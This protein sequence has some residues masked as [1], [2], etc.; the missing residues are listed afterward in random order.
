MPIKHANIAAAIQ[1]EALSILHSNSHGSYIISIFYVALLSFCF[2]N[3]EID[4]LKFFW[5]GSL[6]LIVIVRL[7]D[8]CYWHIKLKNT[9]LDCS[10][11]SKR[12]VSGVILASCCW[13][14]YVV[15]FFNYM[16]IF[17]YTTVIVILTTM[18]SGA[19]TTLAASKVLVVSYP[20]IMILPL[21]IYSAYSDQPYQ[22]TLSFIGFIF[23]ITIAMI[24]MKMYRFIINSIVLNNE[25]AL[26]VKQIDDEQREVR[27]V[28]VELKNAY[29]KINDTNSHLESLVKQRTDEIF[30]LSNR[31]PL[32][33]LLNRSAFKTALNDL[34]RANKQQG[35]TLALLFIDLEGFKQVN[36]S[37]GHKVGDHVLAT[38]GQ[39]IADF[40]EASL[41]GRW[42]GDEF[43]LALPHNDAESA[44]LLAKALQSSIQ[45]TVTYDANELH[46]SAT[47][48]IANSPGDSDDADQIIQYAD[49]A[50]FHRK[51]SNS[52]EPCVFNQTLLSQLNDTQRLVDG[53]K[54]A[55]ENRQL[56]LFYQPIMHAN[57]RDI[58]GYESLLRWKFEG[59]YI[60]P[61]IFIQLAEKIGMINDIG[62]WVLNR[63]CIDASQYMQEK[64]HAV[65]VN[66]SMLQLM[67]KDFIRHIDSALTQSKVE[68]S[69]LHL[70]ITE[71]VLA[72][73]KGQI[74][75][76][77]AAIDQRGIQ[78]SIDDFGTGYS[79]LSQLHELH[80]DHVKI[81]K[82]FVHAIEQGGEAIISATLSIAKSFNCKTVAEGIETAA[83]G[84]KLQQMGVD[85]LQGFYFAK[86]MS[87][88]NLRKWQAQHND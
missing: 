74:Y 44:V 85:Y 42:G 66:V 78:V 84:A 41:A 26:M 6:L 64:G 75:Q 1:R 76:Q 51:G 79:S 24:G 80:A 7:A 9:Q 10:N 33:Q 87:I 36:D 47:I 60:R 32:T 8:T 46:L 65:S 28:N 35:S 81:D 19:A 38:I 72:D 68:P 49:F 43:L 62:I 86:P 40:S 61:D 57:G 88:D 73:S 3:P 39:R 50:M 52:G 83:Q 31:D 15:L 29:K 69:M 67:D 27:K 77:L 5:G 70:E 22:H 12:F 82:S 71:T 23:I 14:G 37:L 21:A 56:E 53:L 59:Q 20:I 16:D 11:A 2:P 48:G 58:W 4:H 18:V 30:Q 13:S 45:Q 55:I 54:H 17:E 63:A 34:L 25:R